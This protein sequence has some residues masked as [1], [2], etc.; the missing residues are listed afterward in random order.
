[1][2]VSLSGF[3]NSGTSSIVILILHVEE[4]EAEREN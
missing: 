1:M 3:Y 2:S 4:T